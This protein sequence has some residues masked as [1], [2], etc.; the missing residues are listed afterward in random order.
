MVFPRYLAKTPSE[1]A[2]SPSG[3]FQP[4]WM[5]CHFSP[6]GTGLSNLPD[7]LPQGTMLILDDLIPI[8]QHDPGQIAKELKDI[9]ERFACD[10]LLLDFQ[11]ADS[12][13][14]QALVRHLLTSIPCPIGVTPNIASDST[15]AVFL[16]PLPPHLLPDNF[17]SPWNGR[18]IWL[19]VSPA[20]ESVTVTGNGII[21]TPRENVQTPFAAENLYCHYR[22]EILSE[23]V[24]F[25]FQR[26]QADLE[27]LL[28]AVPAWGV[29]RT[30]GLWQEFSSLQIHDFAAKCT[31]FPSP[32]GQKNP[33]G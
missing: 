30:V 6:A 2:D 20:G 16:P 32:S 4:A 12:A 31:V 25:T 22:T 18:E 3:P 15:C 7:R 5:S 24:R 27:H 21:C 13:A 19:D 11:R 26:T 10:S 28:Q 14:V 1:F 8:N 17:F 23:T 9:I 33:G 29:T